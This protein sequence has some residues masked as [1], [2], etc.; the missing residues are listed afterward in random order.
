MKLKKRHIVL[1][2]LLVGI[3]LMQ[4]IPSW[5]HCYSNLVYPKL[6]WVITAFSSWIP[7]S[8]GDLFITLSIVA[9]VCVP[10][11]VYFKYHVKWRRLLRYCGEYLLW[12]YIWFYAAWGLNYSQIH[13]LSRTNIQPATYTSALF[14]RFIDR[15]ITLLN[16]SYIDS[17]ANKKAVKIEVPR[18]YMQISDSLKIHAPQHAYLRPK[19]MLFSNFISSVGVSG[20]M[21]P[22]FNEFHLNSNLLPIDYPATYAHE[23]AHLLGISQEAEANFYAYEICTRSSY[24]SIRFSGYFFVL[25]YVL[26]NAKMVMTDEQ[27]NRIKT[28]IRPEIKQLYYYHRCYWRALY[29]PLLGALQNKLYELYL[30]SNKI[31]NG[32]R[33]YSQVV[34]LLIS[35]EQSKKMI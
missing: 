8:I 4:L 29:S 25:G 12:I 17:V 11:F 13:F 18:L 9:L 33:N 3:T 2:I 32:Q 1:I 16:N 20:Y 31:E 28:I 5:G 7:F 14:N 24:K 35:Y 6:S 26:R 23:F 10:I 22:F 27:F 34:E 21:G 15:Y 30:K 19:A